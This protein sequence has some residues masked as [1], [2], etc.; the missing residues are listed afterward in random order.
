MEENNNEIPYISAEIVENNHLFNRYIAHNNDYDLYWSDE[1]SSEFYISLAQRGFIS[2][3]D[4]SHDL[5]LPELQHH[6][7]VLPWENI[8]ISRNV[9]SIIKKINKSQ[10]S[11]IIKIDNN[12]TG[13]LDN[14]NNAYPD[15]WLT[16]SYRELL[17]QIYAEK[18]A[19]FSFHSVELYLDSTLVAGEIGYS[20]GT[21]YTSLSGFSSRQQ[22]IKHLGT[23]QL[24]SL[25]EILRQQG[26]SFWNLGHP[27]MEY[28]IALGAI[29]T[30]RQ[31]FLKLWNK[32]TINS[33][34]K[35]TIKNQE[36]NC[37]KLLSQLQQFLKSISNNVKQ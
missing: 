19:N 26:Y 16:G 12:I 10:H 27:Q 36:Y 20:I 4:E 24:L 22:E 35:L 18:P 31:D 21:V 3:Y 29:V 1:F 5:I 17:E 6:Y 8:H 37:S 11:L 15:N 14:I 34:K 32:H 13:I 23:L 25:A 9:K 28:K 2:V 33:A 30:A 7:A